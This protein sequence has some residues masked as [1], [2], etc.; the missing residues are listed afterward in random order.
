MGPPSMSD[1]AFCKHNY[2]VSGTACAAYPDSIPDRWLFSNDRHTDV[3]LDQVGTTVFEP[4]PDWLH[5]YPEYG[6]P[7][8]A[9][10]SSSVTR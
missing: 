7:S 3:E 6:Q 5:L 2:H 1:C 9:A 8:N 4:D 10:K